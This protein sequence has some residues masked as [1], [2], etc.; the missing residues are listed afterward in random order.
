MVIDFLSF[1][2][3]FLS[4]LKD[5]LLD[6]V[7]LVVG[8]SFCCCCFQYFCNYHPTPSWPTDSLMEISLISYF[9][10]AAFKFFSFSWLLTIWLHVSQGNFLFLYL[11]V[12]IAP[13]FVN[14]S[15][16]ALSL[17]IIIL[18]FLSLLDC[19]DLNVHLHNSHNSQYQQSFFTLFHSFY[20]HFSN[21]LI[22]KLFFLKFAY[23]FFSMIV[24]LKLSSEF[25][26]SV[27]VV[28]SSRI[29][30]CFFLKVSLF[31]KKKLNFLCCLCIV[32]LC[33]VAYGIFLVNK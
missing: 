33:S 22:A 31:L 5:S 18:P 19:H 14:Y 7:L 23:I 11:D 6:A 29:S 27:T 28:L 30:V 1:V 9:S 16:S 15:L 8:F 24:L 2:F 20:F 10:S 4:F 32:F 13:G 17:Y 21:W 25:F 12:H 26:R 3:A